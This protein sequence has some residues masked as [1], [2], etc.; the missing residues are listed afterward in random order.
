[1]GVKVSADSTRVV[2]P[3]S[4][5]PSL[6]RNAAVAAAAG[7]VV[8]FLEPGCVPDPRWLEAL[9]SG[10]DAPDVAAGGGP[11]GESGEPDSFPSV[12]A[13]TGDAHVHAA[14]VPWGHELP[15]GL[16]CPILPAHNVSFRREAFLAVGGLEPALTG[17]G[18]VAD[19]CVC[20]TDHGLRLCV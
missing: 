17:D 16:T 4:A 8:A 18:A 14:P 5:N 13:R 20:L 6:I 9:L 7:E 10:Y 19:L 15:R 1:P 3:T 12:I 11:A 2:S